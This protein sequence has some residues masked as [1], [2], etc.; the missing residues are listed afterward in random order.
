MNNSLFALKKN[1]SPLWPTDDDA[2]LGS[3]TK[4]GRVPR[5]TSQTC[6]DAQT[7]HTPFRYFI[8]IPSLYFHPVLW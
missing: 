5:A 4:C 1:S 3:N 2:M 8:I 6:R 7:T